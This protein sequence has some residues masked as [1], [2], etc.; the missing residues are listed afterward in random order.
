[1]SNEMSTEDAIS[2]PVC[3]FCE[4]ATAETKGLERCCSC[5]K[6]VCIE[7]RGDKK[8]DYL[9]VRGKK[10]YACGDCIEAHAAFLDGMMFNHLNQ[11]V[12]TLP[13][14]MREQLL[15]FVMDE[16]DLRI[17][18]VTSLVE[19]LNDLLAELRKTI[20]V[21]AVSSAIIVGVFVLLGHAVFG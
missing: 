20:N 11:T 3:G 18:K 8:N 7:H 19:T 4:G 10:G 16:V 15:P 13:S 5:R 1:M 17:D 14:N 2:T 6:W 21:A 12:A 9:S